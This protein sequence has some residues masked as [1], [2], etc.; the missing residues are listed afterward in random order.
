MYVA[1]DIGR[2]L[3]E[4]NFEPFFKKYNELH[5]NQI[6]DSMAFLCDLQTRQDL[7][8]TTI[9]YELKVKFGIFECKE[10]IDAWNE[11]L[12]PNEIMMKY[13]AKL[14]S[15][16]YNV[17][18]LSNI[19][20]VHLRYI[21]E[22]IPELLEGCDLHLSCEVGARKPSKLYFKSFLLE[23]PDYFGCAYL[24]DL[25]KNISMGKKYMFN[26]IQFNLENGDE[27]KLDKI[28]RRIEG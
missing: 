12:I 20:F 3:L 14:K 19:G 10:L 6:E 1:F 16:G 28:R 5:L 22:N 11:M 8:L 2:V 25:S 24:D 13:L 7:G 27:K 17:A 18:L 15:E 23:H 26:A 9:S 4:L 21:K